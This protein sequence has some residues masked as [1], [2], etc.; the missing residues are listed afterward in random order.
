MDAPART[1]PDPLRWLWYAVGGPLPAKHRSWVLYD[2][3]SRT[4]P[5]R[6]FARAFIQLLIISVPVYLLIPGEWWVRALAVLLGWLVG[7]QYS[8]FVM[9]GAIEHRVRRA[10]YPPGTAQRVRDLRTADARRAAA[11]RYALRYR[12]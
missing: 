6:H 8:L 2:A 12:R 3:T 11:E 7:M 5:V 9:E 1:R 4:W 10:G